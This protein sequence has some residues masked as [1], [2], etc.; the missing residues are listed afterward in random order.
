MGI[1]MDSISMH[2][3][4]MLCVPGSRWLREA[5]GG[6]MMSES[7]LAFLPLAASEVL[8]ANSGAA[9]K[10]VQADGMQAH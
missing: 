10:A 5:A 1:L 8:G 3:S 6:S 7:R 2:S 9:L 4:G